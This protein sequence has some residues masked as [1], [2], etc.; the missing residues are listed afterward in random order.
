MFHSINKPITEYFLQILTKS[1]DL[2]Y[3]KINV[4]PSNLLQQK[5]RLLIISEPEITIPCLDIGAK[6]NATKSY[7][8][9]SFYNFPGLFMPMKRSQRIFSQK[10]KNHSAHFL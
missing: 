7:C 1:D 6:Y 2:Q 8:K 9:I 5:V 10:D 3:P 4:Y